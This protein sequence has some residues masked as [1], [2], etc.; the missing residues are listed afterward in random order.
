M[1]VLYNIILPEHSSFH[2]VRLLRT[3]LI[4]SGSQQNSAVTVYKNCTLSRSFVLF[5][6]TS[7]VPIIPLLHLVRVCWPYWDCRESGALQQWQFEFCMKGLVSHLR[8]V[9]GKQRNVRNRKLAVAT[10]I[11]VQSR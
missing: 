8:L 7:G 2:A 4:T 10:I 3:I 9:R 11:V 5:L 1:H 6:Q